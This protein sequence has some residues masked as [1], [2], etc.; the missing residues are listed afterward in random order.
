MSAENRGVHVSQ[1]VIQWFSLF[2]LFEWH[3]GNYYSYKSTYSERNHSNSSAWIPEI[4]VNRWL[5][6]V[7]VNMRTKDILLIFHLHTYTY[8]LMVI[9]EVM[10]C[11]FDLLYRG[12]DEFNWVIS[13]IL[14]PLC[15]VF[16]SSSLLEFS[17]GQTLFILEGTSLFW[18]RM[19]CLPLL[20][21]S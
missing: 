18:K 16:S 11:H 10:K 3:W 7:I 13:S 9:T 8:E 20:P 19:L 14:E 2:Y 4:L 17:S 12:W 21:H 6:G 15:F 1:E 5:I